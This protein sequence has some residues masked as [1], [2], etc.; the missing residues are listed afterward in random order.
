MSRKKILFVYPSSYD[1]R[2]RA[3]KSRKAF[4]PS[5]TL[6]YLAALTPRQYETRIVDEL[7]DNIDFDE[8]A[9]L[10]AFTGML[11][12]MPRAIDIARE[13]H[14]R[15]K[16]TIIGG[17]GAFAIQEKIEESGAF[18]SLCIGE[19]DDIWETV[20]DDFSNGRLKAKYECDTSPKLDHLPIPRFDLLDS[21][22]YMKSFVDRTHPVTSIETSRGCPHNCNFCLVTRFFGKRM[23][24]RPVGDVVEE[25]K[26]HGSKFVM[27]TD[28][29]V[30]LNPARARELFLAIKP[31]GIQ[32]FAQFECKVIE[33]PELLQLAAK[34]GCR[35]ALVGIESL[36]PDNLHLI[37]KS[38]NVSLDFKHIVR[39]FKDAGINLL[40]S[41][42]FGMDYDTSD[43]IEWTIEQIIANGVEAI[44]PWILTPIPG[45]SFYDDCKNQGRLIHEDYSLYDCWHSVIRPKHMTSDE[46][47]EAFWAGL[48][49]FYSLPQILKRTLRDKEWHTGGLL[50]NIYCRRQVYKGLHPFA[51]NS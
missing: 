43:T 24:Y 36:L 31:L 8:D 47:M 13:F 41:I 1:A 17:V 42:I 30:A 4:G 26:H 49:R 29:N 34:S 5:R 18:D 40:A 32:W 10:V 19:A 2:G 45:T 38:Q 48:R 28:D 21:R 23:R 3:I 46:L 39:S 7:V 15:G 6:P 14:K 11:S 50:Y 44:A 9:H 35:L 22:K 37:N 51:G 25:I 20:L 33:H 12:H 27:F 16:P